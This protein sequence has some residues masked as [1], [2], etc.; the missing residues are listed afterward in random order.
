MQRSGATAD[1]GIGLYKIAGAGGVCWALAGVGEELADIPNRQ[2][3]QGMS[4]PNS[5]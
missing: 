2:K 3:R 4:G 1:F 5:Q